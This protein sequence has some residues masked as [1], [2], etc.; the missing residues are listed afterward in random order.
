MFNFVEPVIKKNQ[1]IKVTVQNSDAITG[2]VLIK[3]HLGKFFNFSN[4]IDSKPFRFVSDK[5]ELSVCIMII[6]GI[7]AIYGQAVGYEFVPFDDFKYITTN[8]HVMTGLTYE[9]VIWAFTNFMA[10]MWMPVTWLSLMFDAHLYGSNAG[11]YH[12]TNILVHQINALLTFF[13]WK[14]M[15]KSQWIG[16]FIAFFFAFHPLHVESVAWISERKDVLSYFFWTTGIIAYLKYTRKRS[17]TNYSF[18]AILFFLGLMSKPMVVTFPLVLLIIDYWILGRIHFSSGFI[19]FFRQSSILD[20]IPLFLITSAFISASLLLNVGGKG[21]LADLQLFPISIRIQNAVFSYGRYLLDFIFPINLAVFYPHPGNGLPG[22]HLIMSIAVIFFVTIYATMKRKVNSYLIFGWTWYLI[23]LIPVIGITQAG[24]QARADRFVYIPSIGIYLMIVVSALSFIKTYKISKLIVSM[25]SLLTIFTIIVSAY[26][27]TRFW[28]DG[29]SLF[30]HNLQVTGRNF[31]VNGGLGR[32]YL[33]KQQYDNAIRAFQIAL[34]EHP[35]H[36]EILHYLGNAYARKGDYENAIKYY[37]QSSRIDAVAPLM[38]DLGNSY[39]AIN[40]INDAYQSY[41]KAVKLNPKYYQG[42]YNL[43]NLY[44]H[45]NKLK[46]AIEFYQKAIDINPGYLIAHNNIASAYL[47]TGQYHHAELHYKRA[48]AI[49]PSFEQARKNLMILKS[50][51]KQN[52]K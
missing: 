8:P 31:V 19:S 33:I 44:Y 27:Q 4:K 49:D 39:S 37:E 11:G 24:M 36:A 43:G 13:L 22:W 38:N 2:S 6:I 42:Y 52:K 26:Y 28:A 5:T 45:Q 34:E 25:I 51:E 12:L 3:N 18:V 23:T 40:R 14:S 35:N 15:T 32:A 48:L 29:I 17:I 1:T 16:A 50:K 21:A 7:W 47:L 41:Y 10:G 20:K 30:K 9:N 46:K